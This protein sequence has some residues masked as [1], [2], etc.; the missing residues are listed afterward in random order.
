MFVPV[1]KL[2]WILDTLLVQLNQLFLLLFESFILFNYTS[3]KPMRATLFYI[4]V[5]EITKH[6]CFSYAWA[7]LK[8]KENNQQH[9]VVFFKLLSVWTLF[10]FKLIAIFFLNNSVT[11]LITIQ[12]EACSEPSQI[13]KIGLFLKICNDF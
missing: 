5:K 11:N 4:A 12:S 8:E 9:F 13:S 10:L 1:I 6:C 2:H 7:G 3:L